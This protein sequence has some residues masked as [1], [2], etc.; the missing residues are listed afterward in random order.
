MR[1]IHVTQYTF[2]LEYKRIKKICSTLLLRIY[3][4]YPYLDEVI[5][6]EWLTGFPAGLCPL[7]YYYI[8]R[9]VNK[10]K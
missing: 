8:K 10:T 6:P 9:C 3:Q 2:Y 5:G 4:I 1:S 7:P